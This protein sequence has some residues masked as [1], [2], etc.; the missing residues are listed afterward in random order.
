MPVNSLGSLK[1]EELIDWLKKYLDY[2]EII[3]DDF[4][5]K[6][7]SSWYPYGYSLITNILSLALVLMKKAGFEEIV[8]PSFVHGEDFMK[9]CL[10]IKDFS[11][12]V[13]WS[14]LYEEN[15]LHV[16]T[17]TIEAQ[18]GALYVKWLS[19]GKT[20]PFK[21]FT[22]RGVGRYETGRTIPLW[23]ERN[24]WP[25]FE[26]LSAH[27]SQSDFT[28]TIN[29]QVVF[30]RSLFD[31]LGIPTLILERPKINPRVREYSERRIEAV[32]ITRDRRVV[33]LANIYDLGEIFSKV[34]K[35]YY[36]VK[37][38]RHNALI[39]AIGLS[40]RILAVLLAIN[41]DTEGFVVPPSIAP[42]KTAIIPIYDKA[43]LFEKATRIKNFFEKKG[44]T[45]RIFAATASLGD[46]RK[47]VRAMGIPFVI[48]IG[49]AEIK[50]Q[51]VTLKPRVFLTPITAKIKKTPSIF[52][53]N[54]NKLKW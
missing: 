12:R 35:I 43:N 33:I 24:V 53:H 8:L 27:D 14:S 5:A 32:T 30:M 3:N 9:E 52:K 19:S 28:I 54:A 45:S 49:P 23:K 36:S 46:R 31:K 2:S 6:G 16:V 10:H 11:E 21:Y 51:D 37:N 26:G 22:V 41:G 20:L 25:F 4:P 50:T 47:K 40:G 15:D 18:L 48:E 44:V 39:S 42:V 1:E 7:A 17:P 13:Y 29:Q 38:K 34:Y